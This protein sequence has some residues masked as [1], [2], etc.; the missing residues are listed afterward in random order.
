[1]Q[2]RRWFRRDPDRSTVA[3]TGDLVAPLRPPRSKPRRRAVRSL[4]AA[5]AAG[6]VVSLSVAPTRAEASDP[7]YQC[8][9]YSTSAHIGRSHYHSTWGLG[10]V[11]YRA[12]LTS[13]ES[14]YCNATQYTT[15]SITMQVRAHYVGDGLRIDYI[16]IKY[17]RGSKRWGNS[18]FN[19][20]YDRSNRN[21]SWNDYGARMPDWMERGAPAPYYYMVRR[22]APDWFVPFGTVYTPGYFVAQSH[23]WEKDYA[24]GFDTGCQASSGSRPVKAR[25]SA[26]SCAGTGSATGCASATARPRACSVHAVA[27][28]PDRPRPCARRARVSR[29]GRSTIP[30]SRYLIVRALSRARSASSSW[31]RPARVRSV[32]TSWAK[33]ALR[34]VAVNACPCRSRNASVVPARPVDPT[35][36]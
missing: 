28:W 31:V 23:L 12:T 33:K 1:M 29:R 20:Y 34:S 9:V 15:A 22:D 32:R 5:L 26:G 27:V 30:F 3:L 7:V 36:S 17:E 13:G 14:S 25:T 18:Q 16:W 21:G 11:Y 35:S 10:N 24:T 4:A 8:T 6:L 19:L 2:P